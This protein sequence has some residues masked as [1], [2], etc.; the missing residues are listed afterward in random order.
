MPWWCWL[1]LIVG[2]VGFVIAVNIFDPPDFSENHERYGG[3]DG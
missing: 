3:R 1:I 2:V